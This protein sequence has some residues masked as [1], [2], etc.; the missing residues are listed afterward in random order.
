MRGLGGLWDQ[1]FDANRIAT[2]VSGLI[3]QLFDRLESD[4]GMYLTSAAL[5][6]MTL[7]RHGVSVTELQELLSL[8]DDVLADS[9]QCL[10]LPPPIPKFRA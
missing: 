2:T 6:Y 10:P 8:E 9:Y 3:Y 4:H 1:D 7:A 5:A